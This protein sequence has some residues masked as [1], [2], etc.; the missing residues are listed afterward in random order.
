[1]AIHT[2]SY[3]DSLVIDGFQN[4]IADNPFDGIADMRNVNV[5]SVPGEASVLFATVVAS[6]PLISATINVTGMAS[7][8]LS[9]AS[10]QNLVNGV[11]IY[12]TNVGSLTGVDLTH[13]YWVYSSN[14]AYNGTGATSCKLY[15]DYYQATAVTLGGTF[16][17]ATFQ[18]YNVGN[19]INYFGHRGGL[20]GITFIQVQT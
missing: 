12:F 5:I 8:T 4:G 10:T 13:T 1:M 7:S 11:A 9:F 6:P 3:D 20:F 19:Y 18:V 15:S 17:G 16:T 2:D 14:G